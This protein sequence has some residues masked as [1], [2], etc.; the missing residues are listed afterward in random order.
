MATL[1]KSSLK[2][3]VSEA[4]A[5]YFFILE[6]LSF[7]LFDEIVYTPIDSYYRSAGL[8]VSLYCGKETNTDSYLLVYRLPPGLEPGF[9]PAIMKLVPG[10]AYKLCM[11]TEGKLNPPDRPTPS[12]PAVPALKYTFPSPLPSPTELSDLIDAMLRD[13]FYYECRSRQP[14]QI[15]TSSQLTENSLQA[16]EWIHE[17]GKKLGV[18]EWKYTQ[19]EEKIKVKAQI[20][21]LFTG[22]AIFKQ[23]LRIKY[24]SESNNFEVFINCAIDKEMKGEYL[25]KRKYASIP[26]NQLLVTSGTFQPNSAA[27]ITQMVH[28]MQMNYWEIVGDF[29]RRGVIN[30]RYFPDYTL[31]RLQEIVQRD[32]V[33]DGD[34]RVLEAFYSPSR[35]N[36]DIFPEYRTAYMEIKASERRIR[37]IM[38]L[39]K[40]LKSTMKFK[41]LCVNFS[42]LDDTIPMEIHVNL[43]EKERFVDYYRREKVPIG[44]L[45]ELITAVIP[46]VNE[47]KSS[48]HAVRSLSK[49]WYMSRYGIVLLPIWTGTGFSIDKGHMQAAGEFVFASLKRHA[50]FINEYVTLHEVFAGVPGVKEVLT[51]GKILFTEN[52]ERISLISAVEKIYWYKKAANLQE[53]ATFAMYKRQT[54]ARIAYICPRL[55]YSRTLT[56]IPHPKLDHPLVNK[57]HT[58]AIILE[59]GDEIGF[60]HLHLSPSSVISET[61][62]VTVQGFKGRVSKVMKAYK[63]SKCREMQY[64][65]VY[66]L[67]YIRWSELD[68]SDPKVC[69]KVKKYR[70]MVDEGADVYS[71]AMLM[72]KEAVNHD[73]AP[74]PELPDE[75]TS[76]YDSIIAQHKRPKLTKQLEKSSPRLCYFLRMSWNKPHLRPKLTDLVQALAE[77]LQE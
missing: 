55:T 73:I 72:Y 31:E 21:L 64:W 48:G 65:D 62:S 46:A 6:E 11:K 67:K 34:E 14:T 38:N 5:R 35:G 47:V 23:T 56:L 4:L 12:E 40:R 69:G 29:V 26:N 60:P 7:A 19:N 8:L 36:D 10:K 45:L 59:F 30:C 2:S 44:R 52:D 28:L 74:F 3:A 63:K 58:L 9:D 33:C 75:F 22:L 61:N 53:I 68:G 17:V 27:E 51:D 50:V 18:A 76:V 43:S 71:F 57:F 24:S 37:D 25:Q 41:A 13:F 15:I 20:P 66:L 49:S 32:S 54:V 16:Q 1:P 70:E 39:F 42:F 77:Y